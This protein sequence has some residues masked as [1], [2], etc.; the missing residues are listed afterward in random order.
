MK[1]IRQISAA[2]AFSILWLCAI[3]LIAQENSRGQELLKY[4]TDRNAEKVKTIL[5]NDITLLELTNPR[6]STLLTIAA[7]YGETDLVLYLIGKGANVNAANN[8]GNTPLH[9]AAWASDLTSFKALY[10]K[11]AKLEVKNAQGQTPLQY[12]CMGGNPDI[13]DYCIQQGMDIH[14]KIDD[15]SRDR[16]SVV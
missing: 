9:Y 1:S 2:C 5:D 8:F 7:S 3:P 14:A 11:G 15:G 4:L 13:L 6:G 16:K 10:N 12:A